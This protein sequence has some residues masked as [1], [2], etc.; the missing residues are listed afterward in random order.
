[1]F[2][3]INTST[4]GIRQ[5]FGK[6]TNTLAPGLH[7]YLP[8]VQKITTVSNRLQQEEFRFDVKTSDNV[9]TNVQIDVQFVVHPADSSTAHFS[10][11]KPR[12]QLRSYVENVI[13]SVVPSMT[14]DKLFESQNDICH[15]VAAQVKPLMRQFGYT[16][17]NTLVTNIEPDKVVRASMN[18]I[19]AS[20]RLK[21]SAQ[22]KADADYIFK[23][24]EAEGDRDRKRLQGEGTAQQR[25]AILEGYGTGIDELAKRWGLTS[26]EVVDFVLR[27]QQ[28]DVME[29]LSKSNNAKVL[30][31]PPPVSMTEQVL[32]ATELSK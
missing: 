20:E 18:E 27:M 28:I 8:I 25:L 11:T 22:N 2:K 15:A 1:M 24:R 7:F 5:T 19:N 21:E 13:R 6:V 14:L 4:T 23:V 30:I 9:F 26:K 10:M 12:E 29:A 3:F 17:E 31:M 16:I 32:Q